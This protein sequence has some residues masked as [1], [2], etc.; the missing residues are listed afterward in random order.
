MDGSQEVARLFAVNTFSYINA[1]TLALPHL[2][3]TGGSIIVVSSAAGKQGMPL[4]APYSATKHALRLA[5]LC[6]LLWMD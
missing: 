3:K 1:A 4:V 6:L 5:T 2:E